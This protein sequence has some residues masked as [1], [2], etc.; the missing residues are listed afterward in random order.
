[1]R[2]MSRAEALT[3]MAEAG[4]DLSGKLDSHSVEALVQWFETLQCYELQFANLAE[5]VESFANVLA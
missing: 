2:P 3:R 5:A 1:L 4:Y